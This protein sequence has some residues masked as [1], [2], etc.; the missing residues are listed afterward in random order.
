MMHWVLLEL[1]LLILDNN[2]RRCTTYCAHQQR[3]YQV[4]ELPK[5]PLFEVAGNK[6]R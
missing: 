5:H 1:P 2:R 6:R 3:S 4:L